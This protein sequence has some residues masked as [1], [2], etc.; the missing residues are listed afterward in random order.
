[1]E[2]KATAKTVRISPSK[3]RL[4]TRLISGRPVPD[5]LRILQFSSK[6]AARLVEKVLRSAVA[7]AAARGAIQA[8]ELKVTAATADEGPRM[9]RFRPAPRGRAMRIIKRTSHISVTVADE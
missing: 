4:V 3:A 6:K 1:M 2:A 8:E 5:A 7:N 9:R